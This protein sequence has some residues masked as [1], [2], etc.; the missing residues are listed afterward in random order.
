MAQIIVVA[1]G[2]GGSGKSTFTSGVSRALAFS[3]AKVLAIDCDIGLRSLDLLLGLSE[4]V[5]FNWGDLLLGRCTAQQATVKSSVDFLAAPAAFDD[6][7]TCQ[8]V[9]A[10][11]KELA[12]D[13]DY[14]LIDSPAGLDRGFQLAAAAAD[15]GVLIST[16]DSVCV[17]SC[18]AACRELD[19]MG[20]NDIRLVIN[21][22]EV[23]P[24]CK[25]KLL[26]IDRCI[27]ET[28]AQLLGVV[29]RDKEVGFCSVTGDVPGE[30]SPSTLAFSRIAKR[31]QGKQ[32][33]LVCE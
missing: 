2:K 31:L 29:P 3:G 14:V 26:N 16:P 7:F 11:F 12:K 8:A 32:V 17:R 27:D 18:N 15:K 25:N 22:F 5:V 19:S 10:L 13:Y 9:A 6:A 24:V 33:P 21:M 20:I 30:F 28:G 1:S 23:K 4:K